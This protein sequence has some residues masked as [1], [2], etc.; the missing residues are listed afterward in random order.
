MNIYLIEHSGEYNYV[1]VDYTKKLVSIIEKDKGVIFDFFKENHINFNR[2]LEEFM[3]L[4]EYR[5]NA[6][7][8]A[9][10]SKEDFTELLDYLSIETDIDDLIENEHVEVY[11]ME[12]NNELIYVPDQFAVTTMKEKYDV[13]LE[14]GKPFNYDLFYGQSDPVAGLLSNICL[15]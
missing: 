13:D 8:K 11:E 12:D 14:I 2:F 9:D 10:L 15:N 4:S 6:F 1:T 5:L 3:S 7:G